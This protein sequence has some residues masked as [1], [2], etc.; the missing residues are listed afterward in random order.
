[1]DLWTGCSFR[2]EE[3]EEVALSVDGG[4]ILDRRRYTC[5]LIRRSAK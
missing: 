3:E 4:R 2:I 1:M 5:I